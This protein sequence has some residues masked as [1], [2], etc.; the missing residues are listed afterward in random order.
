MVTCP[1]LESDMP[2]IWD[3]GDKKNLKKKIWRELGNSEGSIGSYRD[4]AL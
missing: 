1:T 3:V 2:D 4:L